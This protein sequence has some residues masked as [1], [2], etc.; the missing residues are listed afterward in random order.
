MLAGGLLLALA[1]AATGEWRALD[2][3][4]FSAPSLAAFG[5]LVLFGSILAFTAYGFLLR[6]TPPSVV[7]TYAF[8]NPVVAV[9]LGW[10]VLDE[11]LGARVAAASA[12][13]LAAVA[14]IFGE[15]GGG[16]GAAAGR[17]PVEEMCEA[18]PAA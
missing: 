17:A 12:M 8:V 2:P 1:G 10:A 7:A 18:P 11:P 15:H 16:G 14:L 5:Y 4:R 13:I 6:S 9:V 3:A